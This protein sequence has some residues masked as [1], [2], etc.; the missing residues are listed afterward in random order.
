MKTA[1]PAELSCLRA[2]RE[3]LTDPARWIRDAGGY[4][5]VTAAGLGCD[6][7]NTDAAR[8]ELAGAVE[9]AAIAEGC[10]EFAVLALLAAALQAPTPH[11]AF[12]A[13]DLWHVAPGRTHAE[14]LAL[15]DRAIGGAA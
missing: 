4:T 5:T 7:T 1:T 11:G 2:A 3:L 15:L 12:V 14:V 6:A 8:W 13:L 9:R 10:D